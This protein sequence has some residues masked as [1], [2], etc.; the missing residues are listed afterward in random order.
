MV[1]DVLNF[2]LFLLFNTTIPI[3]IFIFD[4]FINKYIFD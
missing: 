1:V 4:V 3:F 2:L